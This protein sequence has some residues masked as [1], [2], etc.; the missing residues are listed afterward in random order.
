MF[1][2]EQDQPPAHGPDISVVLVQHIIE[3]LCDA[4][5]SIGVAKLHQELFRENKTSFQ[6]SEQQLFELL[7]KY[8][9]HFHLSTPP[10]DGWE[11]SVC[12][13]LRLCDTYC[14]NNECAGWPS[15]TALHLCKFHLLSDCRYFIENDETERCHFGHDL[16]THHNLSVL[17]G[18]L[19]DQLPFSV[20]RFLLR[21][22]ENRSNITIPKVCKFY[23]ESRCRSQTCLYM[24]IC[25]Y[26]LAGTCRDGNTC[27]LN[28]DVCDDQVRTILTRHGMYVQRG[29]DKVLTELREA[30]I[31]N[32][33]D[34]DVRTVRSEFSHDVEGVSEPA[35][36][37][38]R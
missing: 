33:G 7:N 8:Y 29:P 14:A 23:N 24:H 12:T 22:P 37:P 2:A 6:I 35:V 18:F 19:L 27:Y 1:D 9:Q 3:I 31:G 17:R 4:G 36:I 16:T 20:L 21:R 38:H 15:C 5:G 30:G 26:Y 10:N 28:H 25:G 11:V 34:R 13:E 32:L